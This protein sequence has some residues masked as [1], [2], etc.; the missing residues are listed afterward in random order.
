MSPFDFIDMTSFW[1]LWYWILTIVAWSM[2]AH[3][4]LGV[5][6]DMII[7]ADRKGGVFAE[8][9]DAMVEINVHRLLFYFDRGGVAMSAILGFLLAV[10]GTLGFILGLEVFMAL[11]MLLAP[12]SLVM[13][14]SVRFAIKVRAAG[15][16]GGDLRKKMRWRR[17]WNQV[18]GLLAILAANVVAV[19]QYV[20]TI[21]P[22]Y[23]IF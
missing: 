3:W 7:N 12:L 2:I 11:F 23:S 14:F 5:P 21:N 6:I 13:A 17:F 4:T 18:I 22:F 8:H 20:A 15:W 19:L 10:I 9:C 16:Q 1:S